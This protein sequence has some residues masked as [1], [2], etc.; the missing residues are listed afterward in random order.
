ME[1]KACTTGSTGSRLPDR[2]TL[3]GIRWRAAEMA[4][5]FKQVRSDDALTIIVAGDK[6]NPEPSTLVVKFPGGHIELARC[7]DGTYWAHVEAV[8]NANI[9]GSRVEYQSG[10]AVTVGQLPDP[11]KVKKLSIRVANTVPHFDPDE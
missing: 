7:S 5:Q 10:A 2:D 1:S 11:D 4:K 9:V 6:R 8:D 3:Q